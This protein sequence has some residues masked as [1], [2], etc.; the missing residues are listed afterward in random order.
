[1]L[2]IKYATILDKKNFVIDIAPYLWIDFDVYTQMLSVKI[3]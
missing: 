1:M 2:P 3:S